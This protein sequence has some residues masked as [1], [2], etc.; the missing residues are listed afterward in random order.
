MASPAAAGHEF[1]LDV[2]DLVDSIPVG[3]VLS[4]GDLAAMLGSRA[5]RAVGTVLRQSGS[6]HAWWRVL[7]SGGH[8]PVG[9]EARAYEHYI[10]EETPL[11]RTATGCG[12]RVDYAVARW[13]PTEPPTEAVSPREKEQQ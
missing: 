5:S 7:R 11:V 4:Y 6:G 2:L 13:I 1:A 12:Y 9:H 10:V 8:P 3:R